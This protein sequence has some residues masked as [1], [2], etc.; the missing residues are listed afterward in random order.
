MRGMPPTADWDAKTYHCVSNPQFAWGLKVLTRL[1]LQGSETVLDAGCGTGRLT[2]ELMAR[3]PRGRVLAL[4]LSEGM[5]EQ[6]RAQ[7]AGDPRIEFM[8]ADLER[9]SLR[10]VVDAVFSTATFHW[11]LDHNALFQGLYR[12]LK[13]GGRLVAQCGGGPNLARLYARAQALARKPELAPHFRDWHEPLNFADR[14][15]TAAR[16]ANAG[17]SDIQV[18]LEA[19][20]T[21]FETEE[22]LAAFLRTVVLRPYLHRLPTDAERDNFVRAIARAC[23]EDDPPWVLDYWRLNLDARR[24]T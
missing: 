20:P 12:A 24:P 4:D 18:T 19:A 15:T 3:L 21:P 9:L 5:L 1:P 6:A 16:L 11:V 17:F 8:Q 10:S 23:G 7:L 14:E 2:R 22:T 13:P